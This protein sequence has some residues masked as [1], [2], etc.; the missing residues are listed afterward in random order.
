MLF[1]TCEWTDVNSRITSDGVFFMPN[2]LLKEKFC[3]ETQIQFF[4]REIGLILL[5]STWKLNL[6]IA[7]KKSLKIVQKIIRDPWISY[8]V[9]VRLMWIVVS[10]SQAQVPAELKVQ[11]D[12]DRGRSRLTK[13]SLIRT[14]V[15][16]T[17]VC[18][19]CVE[20]I[21]ANYKKTS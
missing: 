4:L 18:S 13:I 12:A 14:S 10:L 7:S 1:N 3:R 15:L 20:E 11:R 6:A 19:P 17:H 21:K 2:F 8:Q 9:S 16:W 5:L